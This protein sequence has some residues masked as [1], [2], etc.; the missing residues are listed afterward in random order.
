MLDGKAGAYP[1]RVQVLHSKIGSWPHLQTLY[2]AG[3]A[4]QGPTL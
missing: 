4:Y 2:K 1:S 3:K